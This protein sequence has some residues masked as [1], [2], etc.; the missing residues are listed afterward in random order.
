MEVITIEPGL[1]LAAMIIVGA[2]TLAGFQ[3]GYWRGRMTVFPPPKTEKE[4][5]LDEYKKFNQHFRDLIDGYSTSI[6]VNYVSER[7]KAVERRLITLG[8]TKETLEPLGVLDA[9]YEEAADG[10]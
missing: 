6:D 3:I 5:L 10:N 7:I 8:E 2:F 1:V 9:P 4:V